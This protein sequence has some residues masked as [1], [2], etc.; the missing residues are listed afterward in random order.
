MYT[1]FFWLQCMM[2]MYKNVFGGK[3]L[4]FANLKIL[5]TKLLFLG[6]LINKV[7]FIMISYMLG[8][9]LR[10]KQLSNP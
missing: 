6:Y 5:N 2:D 9:I 7:I 8:N 3:Q 4:R 10:N 1:A